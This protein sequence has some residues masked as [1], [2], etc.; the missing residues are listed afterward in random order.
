MDIFFPDARK[1]ELVAVCARDVQP[2]PGTFGAPA[3]GGGR[4]EPPV[5][6]ISL[7][8]R[9]SKRVDELGAHFV[10]A[11]ADRRTDCHSKIARLTPELARQHA[12][13][14]NRRARRGS[15]PSR[16]YGRDGAGTRI[17]DEQ[18]DAISRANDQSDVRRVRDEA[19]G[20]RAMLPQRSQL[21]RLDSSSYHDDVS[22]MNLIQCHEPIVTNAERPRDVRPSL[23]RR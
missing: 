6:E 5:D 7:V 2:Q 20:I 11:G 3:R 4:Q 14:G 13:R 1:N 21:A 15:A 18:R 19:V 8:S 9:C 16:V 10:A 17:G 23:R 22:A 12:D